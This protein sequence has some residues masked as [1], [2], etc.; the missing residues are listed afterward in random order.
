V[1]GSE[2]CDNE[3][4]SSPHVLRCPHAT[5]RYIDVQYSIQYCITACSGKESAVFVLLFPLHTNSAIRNW[6]Q[7]TEIY[8]FSDKEHSFYMAAGTLLTPVQVIY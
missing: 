3:A 1:I 6:E 4:G 8:G 2:K 5:N 7:R